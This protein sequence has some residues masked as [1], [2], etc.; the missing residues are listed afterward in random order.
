MAAQPFL[1][2]GHRHTLPDADWSRPLDVAGQRAALPPD[3]WVRGIFADAL[4]NQM[5]VQRRDPGPYDSFN[6]LAKYPLIDYIDMIQYVAEV[7]YPGLSL[8]QGIRE[9]GRCIYPAFFES[10]VG[11]AIFVVAGRSFRRAV[12]LAP[13]VYNG[14]GMVPGSARV[15]TLREG[16]AYAE[17]RG[18]WGFTEAYHVGIW[19]GALETFGGVGSVRARVLGPSDVDLEVVWSG[20]GAPT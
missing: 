15:T 14:V 2:R 20:A 5:R 13:K 17:L 16:Y 4:V 18:V 6:V 19:E 7:V 10:M 12:E 3:G 11:K 8:R 1:D 9:L